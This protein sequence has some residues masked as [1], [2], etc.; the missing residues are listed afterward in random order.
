MHRRAKFHQN[1][2]IHC[3]DVAIFLSFKMAAIAILDF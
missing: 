1:L 3:G 2:S